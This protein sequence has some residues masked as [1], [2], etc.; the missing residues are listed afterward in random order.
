[1]F[2]GSDAANPIKRRKSGR[3]AGRG[4]GFQWR[5]RQ[6][7]ELAILAELIHHSEARVKIGDGGHVTHALAHVVACEP[8]LD[9]VASVTGRKKMVEYV[10]LH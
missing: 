2:I 10:D 7:Q 8:G 1:L 9:H 6:R 4:H 5:R 3:F